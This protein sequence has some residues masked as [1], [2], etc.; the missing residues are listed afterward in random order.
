MTQ[1]SN[2]DRG[3]KRGCAFRTSC[4]K[5][6]D[7]GNG[8]DG[9]RIGTRQSGAKGDDMTGNELRGEDLKREERRGEERR[10]YGRRNRGEWGGEE[11]MG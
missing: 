9:H 8:R 7:S 6:A 3:G 2:N 1:P 4:L 11:R 5:D 10:G